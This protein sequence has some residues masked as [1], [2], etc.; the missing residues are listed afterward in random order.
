M[1]WDQ[2]RWRNGSDIFFAYWEINWLPYFNSEFCHHNK[3]LETKDPVQ[4]NLTEAH[5]HLCLSLKTIWIRYKIKRQ[6]SN[7]SQDSKLE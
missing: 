4:I 3:T 7:S 5:M 6:H 2:N 1:R